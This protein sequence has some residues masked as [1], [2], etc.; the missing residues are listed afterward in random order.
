MSLDPSGSAD[1]QI[2]EAQVSNLRG[3]LG[4]IPADTQPPPERGRIMFTIPFGRP[5]VTTRLH[6][7][8]G[9]PS[10]NGRRHR[11]RVLRAV[12]IVVVVA[13]LAGSASAAPA[14]ALIMKDGNICD[15]IRHMGC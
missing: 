15:P 8:P 3:E 4:V 6:G 13:A 10:R 1:V 9:V 5:L 12:P 11:L 14:S 7:E 2:G